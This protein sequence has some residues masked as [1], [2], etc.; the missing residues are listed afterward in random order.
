MKLSLICSI[1]SNRVQKELFFFFQRKYHISTTVVQGNPAKAKF[2]PGVIQ[3]AWGATAGKNLTARLPPSA[4]LRK[5]K[6][7]YAT[8][9]T[10]KLQ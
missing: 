1:Y 7:V 4:N 3:W 8:T 2:I 10:K 6:C 5:I 9:S